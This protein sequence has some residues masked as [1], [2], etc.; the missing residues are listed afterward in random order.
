MVVTTKQ[1]GHITAEIT[2]HQLVYLSLLSIIRGMNVKVQGGNLWINPGHILLAVHN[3]IVPYHGQ[4]L[5][6]ICLFTVEAHLDMQESVTSSHVITGLDILTEI[7]DR[8]TNMTIGNIIG[9]SLAICIIGIID[10]QAKT[11]LS[12][13]GYARNNTCS[14][15]FQPCT[16]MHPEI[17]AMRETFFSCL[18]IET[19]A[20]V[21]SHFNRRILVCLKRHGIATWRI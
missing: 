6:W 20:I 18:L 12:V 14:Q 9:A 8:F 1:V 10:R 13:T 15:G 19:F 4:K 7:A 3:K 21:S 17:H 5:Q 2:H 16:T 11:T